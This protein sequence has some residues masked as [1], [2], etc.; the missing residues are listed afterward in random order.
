MISK[1][2]LNG[3]GE[4]GSSSKPVGLQRWRRTNTYPYL[5]RI[6]IAR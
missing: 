4:I 1:G 5:I 2:A 3:G 6:N